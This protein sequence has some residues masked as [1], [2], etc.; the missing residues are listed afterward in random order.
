MNAL[1]GIDIGTQGTKAVLF[2]ESGRAMAQAFEPSHL[3][4]PGPG[5]VEEDPERQ[6]A[7]VCAT[8]KRCA[9]QARIGRGDVAAI[10]IELRRVEVAVGVDQQRQIDYST[11]SIQASWIA[12]SI[13]SPQRCSS[14]S[15]SGT[16]STDAKLVWRFP[17]ALKGLGR[18][19]RC[20]PASTLM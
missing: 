11:S 14:S 7:S 9:A 19:S 1:L 20:T 4:R 2:D 3:E 10:G 6:F 8:I 16:T 13:F 18:T 5:A 15:K 17:W 12:S